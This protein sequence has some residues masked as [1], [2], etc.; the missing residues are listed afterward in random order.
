MVNLAGRLKLLIPSEPCS[1]MV[2]P[3][4]PVRSHLLL[5][6]PLRKSQVTALPTIVPVAEE[7]GPLKEFLDQTNSSVSPIHCLPVHSQTLQATH[8][9]LKTTWLPHLQTHRSIA[10]RIISFLFSLHLPWTR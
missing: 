4:S 10:A 9:P 8:G 5:S 1:L 3:V 7:Q 6:V 2:L